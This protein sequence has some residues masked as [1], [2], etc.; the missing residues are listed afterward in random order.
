MFQTLSASR[1]KVGPLLKNT[2][3]AP[4]LD[5]LKA[6]RKEVWPVTKSCACCAHVGHIDKFT[7]GGLANDKIIQWGG[8]RWSGVGCGDVWWNEV[9][10]GGSDSMSETFAD[11][12][13]LWTLTRLGVGLTP[14]QQPIPN[15]SQATFPNPELHYTTPHTTPHQIN[16]ATK[17]KHAVHHQCV[18]QRLSQKPDGFLEGRWHMH[19]LRNCWPPR[20]KH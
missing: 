17:A 11:C 10:W 3:F 1:K 6:S 2:Q 8:A 5:T 4:M 7:K 9:K 14:Q 20:W 18:H 12:D 15:P 16:A 19:C 13:S